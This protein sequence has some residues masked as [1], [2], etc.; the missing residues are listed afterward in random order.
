MEWINDLIFGSG[1]AHAIFV[2]ALVI[3]SGI[4]LGKIKVFGVSLGITWILFVGIF[5]GH[6]GLGIDEH[7]LHFIKE[8]GLILFIYSIGMQVGPSFFSSFK[9]GDYPEPAGLVG[10]I[11]RCDHHICDPRGDRTAYLHH[12]GDIVG[13]GDQHAWTGSGTADLL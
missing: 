1:V 4:L 11:A 6:L 7:I 5:L 10:G 9:Q 3:S 13:S 2:L 8:F 12:G